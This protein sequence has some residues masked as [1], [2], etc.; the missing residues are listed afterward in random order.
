MALQR[1][2]HIVIPGGTGHIGTL[3]ARHFHEQGHLVTVIARFPKACEWQMVHWDGLE[4]GPWSETLDGADVVINLAGRSVNCRYN[5]ANQRLIRHSRIFTTA[6]VGQAIARAMKQPRLWINA[7]TATIYR[8][9]L[10]REMD[11]ISGELGGNEPNLPSTW[12]F[13]VD[14][15]KDW[16][17]AFVAAQAPQTRRI[18]LRSAIVM[19]PDAGGAFDILL[20]LVRWGFGGSSGSGRQYVSWIHDVDF[21]RAVEFL[22][23]RED[24]E[25]TVNVASPCPLTNREFMCCLRR[26]WCTSYIGIPAAEWMLAVGAIFLR[27]ETEL[28]L[29]S[30]RVVPGRLRDA[31]FEFHF[32]NWRGACQNLVARWRNL[33]Q[34]D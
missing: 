18:A 22:I 21:I 29:K 8:H 15:A 9:S 25:G 32:P 26:A 28:V 30:R 24:F 12:R 7:S 6:L 17:R 13:S 31:H 3:L 16:E 27:T 4:L 2:L 10:D 19:S 33:H 1:P 23:E 14:V 11:E 5:A 20:R 34:E